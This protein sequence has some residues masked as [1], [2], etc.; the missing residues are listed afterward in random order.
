MDTTL[1][2]IPKGDICVVVL[3]KSIGIVRRRMLDLG[4]VDGTKIKVLHA[5]PSGELRA[6]G[7][8]GTVIALRD[9]DAKNIIV[10]SIS[11]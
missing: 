4:I 7:I 2:K 9:E 1:D 5:S 6:Y 3:L 11:D 8:K 10:K